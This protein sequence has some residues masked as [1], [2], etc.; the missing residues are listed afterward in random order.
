MTGTFIHP[1]TSF[2]DKTFVIAEFEL[3]KLRHGRVE[4]W[5]VVPKVRPICFSPF[6]VGV[7]Q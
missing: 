2:V 5:R 6:P 3:R 7:P 1:L 4:D